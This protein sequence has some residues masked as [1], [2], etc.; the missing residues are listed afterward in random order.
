MFE[1]CLCFN[2]AQKTNKISL[3]DRQSNVETKGRWKEQEGATK[4]KRAQRPSVLG[5]RECCISFLIHLAVFLLKQESVRTI[6][7]KQQH[8][9]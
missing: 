4:N 6:N 3:L 5:W 9:L 7:A 8:L 1:S 2:I